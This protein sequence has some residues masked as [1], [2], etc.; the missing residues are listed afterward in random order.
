MKKYF[1]K[2][3]SKEEYA[4]YLLSGKL[5]MHTARY[6][7]DMGRKEGDGQGDSKEGNCFPGLEAFSNID[8]PIYCL[9]T[10]FENDI[11]DGVV[12]ID[13]RVVEDFNCKN[14][15]VVVL[16]CNKFEKALEKVE[17]FGYELGGG[18]VKYAPLAYSEVEES[19]R[20]DCALNLYHKNACFSYQKEYRLV[21]FKRMDINRDENAGYVYE[22]EKDISD[23]AYKIAVRS[24][25]SSEEG[26]VL[27]LNK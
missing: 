21:V 24:L 20:S 6:Y 9:Y 10:I 8:Y 26:Y 1:L 12:T 27:R 16:E 18:C 11:K 25:E 15:Y 23:F 13:K 5:Y 17:T 4:D 7:R 3:V 22:M 14:G 19:F 2:F